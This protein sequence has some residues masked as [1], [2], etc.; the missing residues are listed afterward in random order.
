MEGVM[1]EKKKFSF[2]MPHTFVIIIIVLIATCLL[3]YVIPAGV[4]ERTTTEAGTTMVIVDSF[5]Y[6]ERN[7]VGVWMIP[8]YIVQSCIKQANIIMPLVI[9]GGA[10][11]IVLQTGMFKY[12]C[13]K[14]AKKYGNKGALV[15]PIL[16]LVFALVGLTN[17]PIRFVSFAPI[18]V[19]IAMTLGYDAVVGVSI[20][21]LGIAVGYVAGPYAIQTAAAQ[22]LAELPAYSGVWLRWVGFAVF[23]VVC[24]AYLVRYAEKTKKHP[25]LSVIYNDPNV[26]KYDIIEDTIEENKTHKFVLLTF[27][28]SITVMVYGAMKYQWSLPEAAVVF[29][30]MGIIAGFIHGF[31]PSKMSKIFTT[32]C[33]GA[34]GG[35]VLIGLGA[36][37]ALILSDGKILDSVVHSMGNALNAAPSFLKAP[38][39]FLM[40][41]LINVFVPSGLGQAALVMP[42]MTPVANIAGVTRQTAVIAYKFGEGISNYILPHVSSL[43]GFLAV[44]GIGYGKWMKFMWKLF[45]IWTLAATV[46][47]AFAQM[48]G[49]T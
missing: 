9:I 38:V 17:E 23:Y 48:I 21:L 44:A 46:I 26:V 43:T 31:S 40:N 39:L 2:N 16:M 24:T 47:V 32:G 41:L 29:L 37:V 49:Y 33:G 22:E 12:Y 25:E 30:F 35:A 15:I 3:T 11:E 18:G 1:K 10:L 45:L 36:A 42:V 27:V 20:I 5:E 14:M 8:Y 7:P 13:S 6:V 4:Y 28:L 34:I 19:M